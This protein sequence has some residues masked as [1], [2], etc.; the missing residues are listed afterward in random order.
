[1]DTLKKLN[2]LDKRIQNGIEKLKK[3]E[4]N[5]DS[6]DDYLLELL[7]IIIQEMSNMKVLVDSIDV[8]ES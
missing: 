3:P 1:M 2:D 6:S 4:D 5:L 7:T 8:E